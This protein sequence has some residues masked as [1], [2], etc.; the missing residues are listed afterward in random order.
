MSSDYPQ[1]PPPP[2]GQYQPAQPAYPP[3]QDF[4]QQT[5]G[6]A[7]P[8]P[9]A[10]GP[11]KKG[12]WTKPAMVIGGILVVLVVAIAAISATGGGTDT[13]SEN[14]SAGPSSADDNFIFRDSTSFQGLSAP[15]AIAPGAKYIVDKGDSTMTCSFGWMVRQ[16]SKP[17]QL[18]NLTAGHCGDP[19]QKAYIDP[20]GNEEPSDFELIGQFVDQAYVGEQ[21]IETGADYSLIQ[22]DS[23]LNS[24][25][26]GTP[27]LTPRGQTLSLVGT[28]TTTELKNEKPKFVCHLGFKSG[29]S[30]GALRE[31]PDEMNFSFKAISD[32]GDSGGV[33]WAYQDDPREKANAEIWAA[34]IASWVGFNDAADMTNAKSLE[35]ALQ[36]IGMEVVGN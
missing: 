5:Y 28:V 35:P 16:P 24:Y 33:V 34:G 9:Q 3:L 31:A 21:N 4:H 8:P 32:H 11:Q 14:K 29:L 26:Q 20:V 7:P 15:Q 17:T 30:C 6:Q 22:I 12:R 13:A 27:D 18:Y 36:A 2:G 10:P 1:F 25:V 19:G 23:R